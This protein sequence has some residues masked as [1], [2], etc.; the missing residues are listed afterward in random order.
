MSDYLRSDLYK[1]LIEEGVCD[2]YAKAIVG[3]DIVTPSQLWATVT[4]KDQEAKPFINRRCG[5]IVKDSLHVIHSALTC[6]TQSYQPRAA[7]WFLPTGIEESCNHIDFEGGFS[8]LHYFTAI[9]VVAAIVLKVCILTRSNFA[10]SITDLIRFNAYKITEDV[11]KLRGEGKHRA[12]TVLELWAHYYTSEYFDSPSEFLYARGVKDHRLIRLFE[13]QLH[14]FT[15]NYLSL[16]YDGWC[17]DDSGHRRSMIYSCRHNNLNLP[18][19]Y[20]SEPTESSLNKYYHGQ[21]VVKYFTEWARLYVFNRSMIESLEKSE[22]KDPVDVKDKV[23]GMRKVTSLS[24]WELLTIHEDTGTIGNDMVDRDDPNSNLFYSV[25]NR[26][27]DPF[28]NPIKL[29]GYWFATGIKLK[30]KW[31]IPVLLQPVSITDLTDEIDE[32]LQP[33]QNPGSTS[34]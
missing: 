21:I 20:P 19:E 5:H 18:E 29:W 31:R 27:L 10:C 14:R 23:D 17:E 32:F 28:N 1:L 12:D 33:V 7:F 2:Q 13:C 11:V 6:Y 15:C 26:S 9:A 25:I 22:I 8:H 4:F 34:I 16:S 3:D 24:S 30:G